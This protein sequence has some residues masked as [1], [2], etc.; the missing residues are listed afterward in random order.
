MN[1]NPSFSIHS[2]S[3]FLCPNFSSS[4]NS[5]SHF[6]GPNLS[7]STS[8]NTHDLNHNLSS[9]HHPTRPTSLAHSGILLC[10]YL[11]ARGVTWWNVIY[12][13]PVLIGLSTGLIAFLARVPFAEVW[14]T[15][16]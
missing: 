1:L 13:L 16:L 10:T 6:V 9:D 4:T 11:V 8:L 15:A 3:H 12:N 7:S 5:N 14:Q 2:S